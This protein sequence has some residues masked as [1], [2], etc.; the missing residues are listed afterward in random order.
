MLYSALSV[1][2]TNTRGGITATVWQL[3]PRPLWLTTRKALEGV[4]SLGFG[5]SDCSNVTLGIPELATPIPDK[6]MQTQ[7]SSSLTRATVWG[8]PR[9]SR[10]GGHT[11]GAHY[12]LEHHPA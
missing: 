10:A 8:Q 6:E 11:N 7:A 4:R 3:Q 5:G 1:G 12:P 2:H 9:V